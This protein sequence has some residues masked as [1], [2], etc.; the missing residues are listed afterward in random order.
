[1]WVSENG[2][3]MYLA[4][5]FI[6]R[7]K[8]TYGLG[9]IYT[10]TRIDGNKWTKPINLGPTINSKHREDNPHL[11]VDGKVLYF[12]SDRP[13]GYGKWDIYYSIRDEDGTWSKPVNLGPRI[14]TEAVEGM[15]FLSANGQSLYFGRARPIKNEMPQF[16][17]TKQLSNRSW[18]EPVLIDLGISD[19]HSPSL[20]TD[21]KELYF[22][23]INSLTGD[24][25]IMFSI[26]KED[27]TWDAPK[28]I[29]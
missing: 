19:V 8:G 1:M 4:G 13:E 12:D 29:D 25:T 26:K 5:G 14:N 10:S 6:R 23:W 22:Q 16:Y 7:G 20:T 18:S 9:D 3:T 17:V 24:I 28:P 15:A 2:R 21:E 11:S 27:G